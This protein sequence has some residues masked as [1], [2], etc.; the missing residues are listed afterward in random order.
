MMFKQ[1]VVLILLIST[2]LL[3]ANDALDKAISAEHRKDN[4]ARDMFRNPKETI[5]FFQIEPTH[6]VIEVTPGGSG[7]YTEI[8]AP[9]LREAGKLTIGHF[10]PESE[11]DY[12]KRNYKK[13]VDKLNA[14]PEL[15]NKVDIGLFAPPG[16][17]Q[18][19]EAG[20]YDRVVTFRNVHNWTSNGDAAMDRIFTEFFN[21]LKPGGKLGVIDHRLPEDRTKDF[22][23]GYVKESYVIALAE[24]AGF[25]LEAKSELNA[26]AKDPVDS[27]IGVW[28][29]PPSMSRGPDEQKDAYKAI[30][31]SDRMTLLFVKPE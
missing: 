23:G 11:S 20:T 5:T 30:G 4:M 21:A 14:S 2:S 13:L 29:L 3:T 9:Y 19:G 18:I 26:N 8:L 27:A 24:K 16:K 25:K 17:Y 12:Y 22:E 6:R 7:W 10:D 31:E 15:Y 28:R 1:L